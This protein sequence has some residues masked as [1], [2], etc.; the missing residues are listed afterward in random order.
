MV[1]QRSYTRRPKVIS[2]YIRNTEKECYYFIE[3]LFHLFGR[4]KEKTK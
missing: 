4:K 1:K 3:I 2:A